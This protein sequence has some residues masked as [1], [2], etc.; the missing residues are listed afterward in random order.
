MVYE[1]N[2]QRCEY[3]Y[4]VI[5]NQGKDKGIRQYVWASEEQIRNFMYNMKYSLKNRNF[6]FEDS[7]LNKIQFDPSRLGS[8]I[9]EADLN[10]AKGFFG[11]WSNPKV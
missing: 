9:I 8:L 7:L 5:P 4:C 6:N 1:E 2:G 10:I 3:Q 11:S